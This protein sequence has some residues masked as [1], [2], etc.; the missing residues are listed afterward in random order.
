MT[1]VDASHDAVCAAAAHARADPAVARR[2]SYRMGTAPALAAAQPARFD[3]VIASEVIEHVPDP[4]AFLTAC[5]ALL[6]KGSPGPVVVSTLA[7][8][9]RAW[10]VAILGAEHLARLLPV[11]THDWHKF[12][13]AE[14][15]ALAGEA[16]G[17]RLDSLAGMGPDAGSGLAAAVGLSAFGR[18]AG[19]PSWAAS[20]AGSSAPSGGWRLT[21][22]VGINYIGALVAVE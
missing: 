17:L 3:G 9:P 21:Q 14:E 11:G 18:R 4:V 16:A 7:R 2:V 6:K 5:R 13:T 20:L 19:S 8:T 12:L 15:L 22:D 1:G 10:A